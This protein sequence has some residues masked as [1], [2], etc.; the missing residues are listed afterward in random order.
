[1]TNCSLACRA[2]KIQKVY[3]DLR[4]R[5]TE[6][7]SANTLKLVKIYLCVVNMKHR[8]TMK[9]V[10]V[11]R[12]LLELRSYL[13]SIPQYLLVLGRERFRSV[14]MNLQILTNSGIADQPR[15]RV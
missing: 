4:K 11:A 6:W 9:S 10:N 15:E 8:L 13:F 7:K 5:L 1:M 14:F 3:K 12:K 2:Y